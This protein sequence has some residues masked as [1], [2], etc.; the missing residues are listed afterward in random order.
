MVSSSS[1]R[2]T[3]GRVH[4]IGRRR[5]SVAVV[6]A[7]DGPAGAQVVVAAGGEARPLR[8]GPP[9]EPEL[10]AVGPE[11]LRPAFRRVL[12]VL[13]ATVDGHVEQAVRRRYRLD[14]PPGG[15]VG[16]EHPVALAQVAR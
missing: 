9:V 15:P 6:L 8:C 4:P 10:V 12:P 5:A 16:L 7:A 2:P 1:A 14:A 11:A 3:R 13:L